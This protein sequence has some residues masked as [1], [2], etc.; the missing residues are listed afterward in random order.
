MKNDHWALVRSIE[1]IVSLSEAK[2]GMIHNEFVWR[3]WFT[4]A[5]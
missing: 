3:F 2:G 5:L 4:L 1:V